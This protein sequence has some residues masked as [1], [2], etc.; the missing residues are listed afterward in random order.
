MA[1]I[2]EVVRYGQAGLCRIDGECEKEMAGKKCPYLMLTPLFKEGSA[3]FVPMENEELME[4]LC[5][6]LT[7]NEIEG[8]LAKVLTAETEWIRDFRKRS[9]YAKRALASSDRLEALLL[10]KT[11]YDHRKETAGNLRI[12]T[13]DD[14]FLK[15]AEHLIYSEFSYVLKEDYQA[16]ATRIRT[17]LGAFE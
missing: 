9:D 4:R 5:P 1:N 6:P 17:L 2:G 11:I 3:V 12:H 15:D 10:I 14:Y 8:L 16:L 13:T 7:E